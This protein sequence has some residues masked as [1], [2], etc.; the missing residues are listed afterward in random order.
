M[1]APMTADKMSLVQ[2]MSPFF[3]LG[4]FL[5]DTFEVVIV[6]TPFYENYRPILYPAG[7]EIILLPYHF[8]PD[9]HHITEERIYNIMIKKDTRKIMCEVPNG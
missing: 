4:G 2:I 1:T 8:C 3:S 5:Y 6:L 9:K 7:Y